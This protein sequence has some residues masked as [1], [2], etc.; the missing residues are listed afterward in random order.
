M[1]HC[2]EQALRHSR[3]TAIAQCHAFIGSPDAIR[4]IE[5]QTL[6]L[7]LDVM[8]IPVNWLLSWHRRHY[9]SP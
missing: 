6:Q 7:N 9:L 1:S 4:H 3:H 8:V 5:Y 2:H